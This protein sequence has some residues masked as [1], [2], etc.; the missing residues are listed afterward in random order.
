MS[1]YVITIA[2]QYG[3]GGR[4]V[5][6]MLAKELGIEFYDKDIIPMV[7]DLSG[8]NQELFGRVD[9]HNNAKPSLFR[10]P[11]VYDGTVLKPDD[12]DFTS[13]ENLFALQAKFIEQLAAK[14]SCIIIGRCSNYILRN[15]PNVLSV[16]VHAPEEYRIRQAMEKIS[17]G[18][19][20]IQKFLVKDDERKK[21][22]CKRYTGWDWQD[23]TR[24]D[25]CLNSSK[26]GYQN[27]MDAILYRLKL[28]Q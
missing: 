17:G 12:K 18:E 9:E 26:L 28:N 21:E 22:F 20:E 5:G 10:K 11:R 25:L 27:C 8:V 24:Y 14:E 1:N 4:T 23:A 2:R 19:K 13:D 15:Q 16:F 6:Q 7:S 3:S